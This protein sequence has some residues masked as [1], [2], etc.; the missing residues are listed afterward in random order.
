MPRMCSLCVVFHVAGKEKKKKKN[1]YGPKTVASLEAKHANKT[2]ASRS[3]E[4]M[5]IK[6]E[7]ISFCHLL[8][9]KTELE[10]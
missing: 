1:G 5:K 8:T 3:G 7:C 2:S 6:K 9:Y 4:S 10:D